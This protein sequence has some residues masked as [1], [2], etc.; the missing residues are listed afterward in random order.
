MFDSF[1]MAIREAITGLFTQKILELING[2]FSG[3]LG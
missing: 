1:F 3:V 2:V